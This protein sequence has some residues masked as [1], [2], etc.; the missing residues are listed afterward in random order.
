MNNNKLQILI[1]HYNENEKIV[2][3]FLDSLETQQDIKFEAI[4]LSDGGKYKITEEFLSN[5]SFPIQY[6]YALHTG[7]CHTRNLL[8]DHSDAEYIMF[9]DID[10]IF[11]KSD[12]L[13]NIISVIENTGADI[14]GS[15]YRTEIKKDN[16]LYYYQIKKDTLHVHGKVFKRQY[17]INNNIRFPDEMQ[18][19][20]DVNF[21]WLAYG[22]SNKIVWMN[23]DFY[24]W[25]YNEKSITRNQSYFHVKTY[26][27][28]LKAYMLLLKELKKRNKIDL[29]K[30]LVATFVSMIYV[31]VTNPYIF[32]A[33]QEY[34]DKANIAIN[35]C[36]KNIFN[37]YKK[38]DKEYRKEKYQLMLDFTKGQDIA[39][40]FE[41][42]IPWIEERLNPSDII[43][44]GYGVV[45]H[46]L[47]NEL[48]SLK[49]VIYDKYKNICTGNKNKKYSVAFICVNTPKTE[50][51]LCDITEVE[52][53]LLEIDADIYVIKS[54]VL[55]GT[56]DKLKEKTKK[57]IIFS[58][59]YYG[60]TQHCNNYNFDYTILGGEKNDCLELIQIL[61]KV[62]D[63][64]YS[65]HI[66]DSKTAELTKY[67]ENSYL[68]TKVSFCQQFYNLANQIGVNYEELRE[69]FILDPRVNPSHTFVYKDHPYWNSKCLDKDVPA[70][71][72]AFD[73]SLLK[74]IIKFNE[75][76][77]G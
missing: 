6:C 45:G 24:I 48:K 67:M 39:G 74:D 10:D 55:P 68:A 31:D 34:L 42:I 30:N 77:K 15:P 43:I 52:N 49:P 63:G 44:I 64:R 26:P 17:L 11:D 5:Y 7:I 38:I 76:Q 62:Y 1:N 13:K 36:L 4:I 61:Q 66:T 65:F 9:C 35:I 16:K 12:G 29:I 58:P 59:E 20:G 40:S 47:Q 2:K 3:R 37:Y 57:A 28:T 22:L 50:K 19:G 41:D 33:P 23:Y 56:I 70:I 75:K 25:K 71:A 72:E 21:L 46:N 60:E 18:F 27:Q 51:F 54:T 69:L 32:N 14:V 73:A 53:A 8:L